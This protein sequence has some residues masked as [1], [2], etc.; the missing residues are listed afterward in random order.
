MIGSFQKSVAERKTPHSA[1]SLLIRKWTPPI[2]ATA[3]EEPLS[4]QVN[5]MLRYGVVA[6]SLR[7]VP[8]LSKPWALGMG[9]LSGMAIYTLCTTDVRAHTSKPTRTRKK[10]VRAQIRALYVEGMTSNAFQAKQQMLLSFRPVV[11]IYG[12]AIPKG[13]M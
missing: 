6:F 4:A 1:L 10:R 8:G 3:M 7:G 13:A 11:G 5:E 9:T 12:Y 2:Y